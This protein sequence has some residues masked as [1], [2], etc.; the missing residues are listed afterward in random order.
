[1]HESAR[2]DPVPLSFSCRAYD[3]FSYVKSAPRAEMLKESWDLW[4]LA[5]VGA[6]EIFAGDA[7]D[8]SS[9]GVEGWVGFVG[10]VIARRWCF[11]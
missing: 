5:V 1:M 10:H 2:R 4:D 7:G 9:G 8:A 3:R 6:L 11:T